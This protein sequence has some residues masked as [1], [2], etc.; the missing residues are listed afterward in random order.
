LF[1]TLAGRG[2]EVQV[3]GRSPTFMERI[4]LKLDSRSPPDLSSMNS[5]HTSPLLPEP[6]TTT[7]SSTVDRVPALPISIAQPSSMVINEEPSSL[8]SDQASTR[9]AST[10]NS[11]SS[12]SSPV[13]SIRRKGKK[14]HYRHVAIQ[15]DTNESIVGSQPT[16]T[17]H[18]ENASSTTSGMIINAGELSNGR[19]MRFKE[20]DHI[21]SATMVS[22]SLPNSALTATPLSST[23]IPSL[24]SFPSLPCSPP[25][26][27]SEQQ[28]KDYQPHKTSSEQKSITSTY[29]HSRAGVHRSHDE[30]AG[31][32]FK[33]RVEALRIEAGSGWLKVYNELQQANK[34][35][36][37]K[38]NVCGNIDKMERKSRDWESS[39][40]PDE[41][42]P[43][44]VPVPLARRQTVSSD[45]SVS[46]SFPA[47]GGKMLM[48]GVEPQGLNIAMNEVNSATSE[49][50][51]TTQK[52]NSGWQ[53]VS[54]KLKKDDV[55]VMRSL[56]IKKDVILEKEASEARVELAF[57]AATF[58]TDQH[59]P[60]S[61][62][63]V[64]S[65]LLFSR[66]QPTLKVT[67]TSPTVEIR[68]DII[69]Q[70]SSSSNTGTPLPAT[71][72]SVHEYLMNGNSRS[73]ST[74]RHSSTSTVIFGTTLM[75]TPNSLIRIE[76][77]HL[78]S[79][80]TSPQTMA[81]SQSSTTVS[82]NTLLYLKLQYLDHN[83]RVVAWV[84]TLQM[85]PHKQSLFTFF[86]LPSRSS[87]SSSSNVDV[88]PVY[89]VITDKRILFFSS[90]MNTTNDN[91][92][93]VICIRPP[94]IQNPEEELKFRTAFQYGA[95][96][97]VD[98]DYMRQ[99]FSLVY[100]ATHSSVQ[101]G[102][103]R[104][105]FLSQS[106]G[107]PL[108]PT[109]HHR[110][111]EPHQT[112]STPPSKP[113]SSSPLL[114]CSFFLC[115]ADLCSLV[116]DTL[117]LGLADSNHLFVGGEK[118]VR[119]D[120]TH[121]LSH[122]LSA[123]PEQDTPNTSRPIRH[124]SYPTPDHCDSE[125]DE[126]DN[127]GIR[128]THSDHGGVEAE[129]KRDGERIMVRAMTSLGW[130]MYMFLQTPAGKT[131]S[132][133]VISNATLY[134]LTYPAF[135]T[136]TASSGVQDVN[137]VGPGSRRLSTDEST[138]CR[139]LVEMEIQSI[140]RLWGQNGTQNDQHVSILHVQTETQQ[141]VLLAPERKSAKTLVGVMVETYQRQ[142]GGSLSVWFDKTTVRI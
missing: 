27:F 52:V 5:R 110:G 120:S 116:V 45:H 2:A 33:K 129:T 1:A 11:S 123:L 78:F 64:L 107:F 132:I 90:S 106:F 61:V 24:P 50:M 46:Q 32:R 125:N 137:R 7:I 71:R 128:S 87:A 56:T 86:P 36:E 73:S 67:V 69:E 118:V 114:R 25:Q 9:A 23:S 18:L 48:S 100:D 38:E 53:N 10:S 92:G 80:P 102:S 35:H 20:L 101:N 22:F 119:Q 6:Y 54:V 13:L 28:A 135:E 63:S 138:G 14:K 57:Q 117:T 134:C 115:D 16:P 84:P 3:D 21:A 19:R 17:P 49:R 77:N 111:Q 99:G 113:S 4:G 124:H 43:S 112:P 41:T 94:F 109:S 131:P 31:E 66:S 130:F 91:N 127:Q 70:V 126:S 96:H 97:A 136:R 37:V 85:I 89:I 40:S 83:E 98:V 141:L 29:S 47:G 44:S 95:I 142:T 8:T 122:I 74:T 75:D 121:T 15:P 79:S 58:G 60:E 30:L 34:A 65:P 55:Q 72:A 42:V 139:V 104:F 108:P 76:P 140:Q 105:A 68:T 39:G 62:P 133:L 81:L 103:S 93:S 88:G 12:T 51:A 59:V 82:N 26:F